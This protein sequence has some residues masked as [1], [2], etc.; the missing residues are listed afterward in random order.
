MYVHDTEDVEEIELRVFEGL[1]H[2]VFLQVFVF[3]ASLVLAEAFD[4]PS[5]LFGC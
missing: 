1:E 2:L 4:R 3:N 5:S